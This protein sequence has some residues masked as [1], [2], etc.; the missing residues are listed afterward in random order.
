MAD[1]DA[2]KDPRVEALELTFKDLQRENERLRD[3]RSEIT[4]QLGPLPIS[5]AIVAGLVSGFGTDGKL[6]LDQTVAIWA[7]GVFGAMVIVSILF[8]AMAPY[9][10]LRDRAERRLPKPE[11]AKDPKD[12]YRRMIKI[13]KELRGE[14]SR[15]AFGAA[16][17]MLWPL[18]IPW[19]KTLQAA[20]DKEWKGLFITKLL[21]VV[22]VVLLIVARFD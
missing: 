21:F 13:E 18:P 19:P 10:K 11:E 9:R 7:L 6:H 20:C 16:L 22:V 5:A 15:S 17:S 12:W 4:K 3:A 2:G 1:A 14:S 8:S